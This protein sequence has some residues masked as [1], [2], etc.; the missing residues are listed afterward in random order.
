MPYPLTSGIAS[1]KPVA[2]A[3]ADRRALRRMLLE[4][5]RALSADVCA[6]FSR[7]ICSSLQAAFPQFAANRV[8]FC[9][10]VHNEPD[11][12]PLLE[13]WTSQGRDGYAALLP[14]VVEENRPLAFRAWVP[15]AR[16]SLDRYGIP[17]PSAGDFLIPQVLLVPLL[18]FDARGYRLGYGGGYFDRTLASLQPRPF[19]VGVGFELSRLD[20]IQPEEY[21]QPL[22]A[23]VTEVGVF[24]PSA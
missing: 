14:V 16:L 10:P 2:S 5:R 3:P 4:R 9:W 23:M 20:S 7:R 11:L 17:A 22:D 6:Q 12:R 18:G 15:G 13:E 1:A 24:Q 8:A 21:D 19:A